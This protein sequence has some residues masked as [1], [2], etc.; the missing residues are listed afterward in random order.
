[1]SKQNLK[2]AIF[3]VLAAAIFWLFNALNK[4]GYSTK[5]AYPLEIKYDDSLYIPTSVL[6]K[7]INVNLSSTG[8][9]LLRDNLPFRV[10]PLVYEI[11]NPLIIKTLSLVSLKNLLVSQ[12]KYAKVNDIET[13]LL[14]LSFERKITKIVV[15]KIDSLGVDLQKNFVVSS[16]INVSPAT[17]TLEGAESILKNYKDTLFLTIPAKKLAVNFDEKI[18]IDLPKHPFVKASIEKTMVSFEIAELLRK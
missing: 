4:D 13:E 6:P 11:A 1:M 2:I 5:V 9:N 18:N 8:W 14:L 17:M 3:C 7:K 16:P 15:L 12:L 10:E